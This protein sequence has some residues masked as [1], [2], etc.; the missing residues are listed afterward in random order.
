M[1]EG[2]GHAINLKV[3]ANTDPWHSHFECALPPLIDV[4]GFIEGHGEFDSNGMV[5]L[6]GFVTAFYVG[7]SLKSVDEFVS[8]P[9]AENDSKDPHEICEIVFQENASISIDEVDHH[10]DRLY[11]KEV[12][13][14]RYYI[15]TLKTK[16]VG[17]DSVRVTE[18]KD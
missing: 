2:L 6:R 17:W 3:M 12:E 7:S 14:V 8:G 13:G 11:Y 18:Y 15:A 10:I 16:N 5:L 4:E 9:L 1:V